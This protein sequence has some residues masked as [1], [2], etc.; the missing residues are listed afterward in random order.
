MAMCWT[1]GLPRLLKQARNDEGIWM[2]LVTLFRGGSAA[3]RNGLPRSLTFAR[4]DVIWWVE[5]NPFS[6]YPWIATGA[7]R[8][9]AMTDHGLPPS[10]G[11]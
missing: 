4:N 7:F 9:R 8:A 5:R 6:I 3:Y 11:L 1:T 10:F 2:C